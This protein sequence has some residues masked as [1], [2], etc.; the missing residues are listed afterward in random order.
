MDTVPASGKLSFQGKPLEYFQVTLIADGKRPAVGTSDS[1][2]SF[3]LGTNKEK[4]GAEPGEYRVAITYVGPPSTDPNQGI[5]EFA[6]PP[7]PKVKIPTKYGDPKKSGLSV[8][9]PKNGNSTIS[10]E[11]Q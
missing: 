6:P 11:I 7:P 3:V 4:D 2:G 10:L 9:I 5:N 8:T 1:T